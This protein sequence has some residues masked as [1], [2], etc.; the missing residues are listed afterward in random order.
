M[1]Q[2][3]S[4]DRITYRGVVAELTWYDNKR[5]W[6]VHAN[7]NTTSTINQMSSQYDQ[8]FP[9]FSSIKDFRQAVR[10]AGIKKAEPKPESTT[11]KLNR[12]YETHKCHFEAGF[13]NCLWEIMVNEALVHSNDEFAFCALHDR[14]VIASSSGGYLGGCH[15]HYKP[16]M[17]ASIISLIVTELNREVFGLLPEAVDRIVMKSLS[18]QIKP[19]YRGETDVNTGGEF[20]IDD[21]LDPEEEAALVDGD[22]LPG[23]FCIR[24]EVA[25]YP[26][27]GTVHTHLGASFTLIRTPAGPQWKL[28]DITPWEI[29]RRLVKPQMI[30][31]PMFRSRARANDFV[32]MRLLQEAGE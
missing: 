12:I 15:I 24:D 5:V 2:Y 22:E 19:Q 3:T 9:M 4:G 6:M 8:N 23:D 20:P 17:R 14:V 26:E 31:N 10:D 11:E 21:D 13:H 28:N 29:R 18:T 30:G 25:H 27:Y 32:E 7:G 1:S 16:T